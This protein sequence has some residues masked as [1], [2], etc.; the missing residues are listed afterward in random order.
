[1]TSILVRNGDL[2]RHM[3]KRPGRM[4]RG[5]GIL[6]AL[7]A[8]ILGA[9]P[10]IAHAAP[11]NGTCQSYN[12]PVALAQGQPLNYTIYGVLCNPVGG[13]SRTVQLLTP[14][15]S[16]G[17]VYWDFPSIDGVA[18]SYVAAMNAAGY[19]TFDFDRLGTGQ[20]SHPDLSLVDVTVGTEAY[21]LHELA[22]DLRVG[23]IGG[24]AF[25]RVML[26]GHSLG[27]GIVW[28]EA[29]TYHDVAGVIVTG[30]TH[31]PNAAAFASVLASLWSADLD[32]RFAGDHYGA[33]YVTT[34]PGT[35]GGDFYYLPGADK[36]VVAEDEVT[37]E[38][39]TD[40]EA[41]SFGLVLVNGISAQITVP[42]LLVMGQQD[43]IFCGLGATDCSSAASVLQSEVP[44]YSPQAQLQVI[45]APNTGHDLN[46]HDKDLLG[47]EPAW[48]EAA[49]A[50]AD[51]YVAP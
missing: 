30:L 10:R 28:T 20:S 19:S 9:G 11:D 24:Q 46:L 37:K 39:A 26:V 31:T 32:P 22:G 23:S 6:P 44:Y 36:N 29:G 14:G 18:Y 16:Y 4:W 40:G 15:A 42:V 1:M 41:T 2:A 49:A 12:V 27:S 34:R 50:W 47:N 43:S 25:G 7:L 51:Q 17:S 48:Y 5:L 3:R 13:A 8:L 35:R 21:I 33:G 45:V 38:T